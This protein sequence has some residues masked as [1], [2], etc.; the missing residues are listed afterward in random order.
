MKK[1]LIILASLISICGYPQ[2]RWNT[3]DGVN[4]SKMV[5][6]GDTVDISN[7]VTL[8]SLSSYALKDT[9]SHYTTLDS[10]SGVW[11][12][13]N[14]K[15]P[16]TG[17]S[18]DVELGNNSLSADTLKISG[19]NLLLNQFKSGS[20]GTSGY[21][22]T[23]AGTTSPPTWSSINT[24]IGGGSLTSGYMPYWNGSY[25]ANSGAYWDATN[26]RVGIGTTSPSNQLTQKSTT[27][28]ESATL[29]SELLSSSNWTS[30]N[31]TGDFSSGFTHST[32]YTTAL[33]NTLSATTGYLY[34]ISFTVSGRTAGTFTITFGGLTS[35]SYSATSAWGPKATSAGTLSITP[36]S[37]FNGTII[38]SIKRITGTYSAIY[39]ILDNSNYGAFE[40]RSNAYSLRNIFIGVSSGAY[41][42]TG[43]SNTGIGTY[44]LFNNTT[45]TNNY[46]LGS[47]SLQNN[48]TG[49]QNSALGTG[50]LYTN[51]TGSNNTSIGYGASYYNTTGNQNTGVGYFA[52]YLTNTG[53]QNSALGYMTLTN[54]TTGNGNS[55]L[56]FNA[57]RYI[58][59]G[60]TGRT[61]G[62][63]GIYIGISSKASADGTNNEIVLGSNAIG[64]G[65]NTAVI[66]NSST[67][68]VYF[69][70]STPSATIYANKCTLTSSI[71]IANDT[72]TASSSNVGTMRYR[73]DGSNNSYLEM[74]MQTGE[75]TYEWVIVK[76]NTW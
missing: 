34:Q 65:S 71:K 13:V 73:T 21:L 32:G 33:T 12:S 30:T 15:I 17:A 5:L 66:G 4:A 6:A 52:L 28:L 70:S 45:G 10:L 53:S 14:E 31:W 50:T 49:S 9:L 46:A 36:T 11:G 24:A 58:T 74:V 22:L 38:I 35:S 3:F 44:T 23:G 60:S 64:A 55:A 2:T 47:Y 7:Y 8:D 25:M 42:T 48:T 16:Y 43:Y 19:T 69:G 61:T 18:Q 76:Q 37:D 72:S 40:I 67:T 57:G 51:T 56:G 75:S 1:T 29:G 54:N 27:A 41:N 26:S 63:N 20:A 68:S 62:E 59:D 39:S